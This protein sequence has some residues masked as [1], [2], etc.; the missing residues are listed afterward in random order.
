MTG[1]STGQRVLRAEWLVSPPS[2]LLSFWFSVGWG[3]FV[4]VFGTIDWRCE[5]HLA[6]APV[7]LCSISR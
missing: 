2:P 4:S 3:S 7:A 1:L 5:V 6:M